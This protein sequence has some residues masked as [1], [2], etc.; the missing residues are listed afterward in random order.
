MKILNNYL[1]IK[2]LKPDTESNSYCLHELAIE[3][4]KRTGALS[5]L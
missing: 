4:H 2:Y 3:I 1:K 5:K